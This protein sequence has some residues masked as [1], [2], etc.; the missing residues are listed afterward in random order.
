MWCTTFVE[1]GGSRV[2]V[3][4]LTLLFDFW[5]GQLAHLRVIG[6][7]ES[8]QVRGDRWQLSHGQRVRLTLP[9]GDEV[10]LFVKRIDGHVRLF[11]GAPRSVV[12]RR[13]L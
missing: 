12:L 1:D 8:G 11:V 6:R 13:S 3:G 9:A 2:E 10:L 7:Y 5:D 4:A